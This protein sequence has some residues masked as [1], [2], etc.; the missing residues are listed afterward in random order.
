[1]PLPRTP[2][3]RAGLT[4]ARVVTA[5]Y[6]LLAE[7]GV[8]AITM[9]RLAQ[10]LGVSPNA[11]YS[12]VESKTALIDDM[13]DGVLAKVQP[14]D[15]QTEY[16][17]AGLHSLMTDTYEILLA[18]QDLVPLYLARRGARGRNA[19]HLGEIMI[20]LLARAGV[21]GPQ[22]RE[23]LRVL[24]VYTIAFAAFA[25]SGTL[26][27]NEEP[28]PPTRELTTNFDSGLHWLLTGIGITT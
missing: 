14:P 28:E 23:A 15:P 12:H 6:E 17:R 9:R 27:P 19:Q 7:H 1:M 22:A 2:G 10:H 8:K 26:I 21:T 24:I 11:L 5:A 25:A 4:H 18:H 3:Q 20:S 13:L 16:P